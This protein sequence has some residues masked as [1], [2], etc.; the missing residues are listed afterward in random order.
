MSS[1]KEHVDNS[2]SYVIICDDV[3]DMWFI[4]GKIWRHYDDMLVTHLSAIVWVN[5]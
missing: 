2:Y 1:C 4:Y 5:F 3:A